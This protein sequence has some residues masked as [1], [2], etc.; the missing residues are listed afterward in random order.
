MRSTTL[1]LIL[2][3]LGIIGCSA[4]IFHVM[5]EANVPMYYFIFYVLALLG[6]FVIGTAQ[7]G[8]SSPDYNGGDSYGTQL[9]RDD[10]AP[11]DYARPPVPPPPPPKRVFREYA[12][13]FSG[14]RPRDGE[15]PHNPPK[16]K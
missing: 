6:A 2:G 9:P 16:E 7:N 4:S 5:M 15:R 8:T 1:R 3:S 12:P 11:V 14:H 13:G 10:G